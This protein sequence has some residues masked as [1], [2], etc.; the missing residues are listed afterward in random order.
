MTNRDFTPDIQQNQ[1]ISSRILAVSPAITDTGEIR[2]ARLLVIVSFIL[3]AGIGI[4]VSILLAIAPQEIIPY[5]PVLISSVAINFLAYIIGRSRYYQLGSWLLLTGLAATGYALIPIRPS[6]VV[7]QIS[8]TLPIAFV[9]GSLLFSIPEFAA[10]VLLNAVIIFS[11]PNFV[12]VLETPLMT[13]QSVIYIILGAITLTV[14]RLR[15]NT[16]RDRL[17]EAERA[18]QALKAIQDE[19]E[20]RISDRT[21]KLLEKT[22]QM[23]ASAEIARRAATLQN[24]SELLEQVVNLIASEFNLYHVGIFLNS[25][26]NEYTI[27]Q[28]SSS[29]EGKKMIKAGFRLKTGQQGIVGAVAE[30]KKVRMVLDVDRS[31]DYLFST[32][33]P[34]TRSEVALPLVARDEV[35]G[36]LDLQSAQADAFSEEDIDVLQ[37]M[38]D[39]IALAISNARLLAESSTAIAQLRSIMAENIQSA[40]KNKI[41]KDKLAYTYTP[42]GVAKA[43]EEKEDNPIFRFLKIPIQL[44]GQKIGQ[45]RLRRRENDNWSQREESLLSELATQVGLAIEN[46]RLLEEAEQRAEREQLISEIT[47][48]ATQ[49]LDV[50]IMLQQLVREVGAAIGATSTFVQIGLD[51]PA[52]ESRGE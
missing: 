42:L 23:R 22:G 4:L 43:A 24:P 6:D 28:A 30:D 26:D 35:L 25:E 52:E 36:V 38:A 7:D 18:N 37:T 11:M 20:A 49:T 13:A 12:P 39:Q 27:F 33:F 3:S 48:R 8:A 10:F 14:T 17:A 29:V 32:D 21:R 19:L 41:A 16:E 5:L 51:D 31:T 40:W 15:N 34:Q 9:I 45:I 46:A 1:S 44:R 2:K 47:S 50:E